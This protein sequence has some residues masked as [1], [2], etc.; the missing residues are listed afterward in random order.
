MG[1]ATRHIVGVSTL[2]VVDIEARRGGFG[3]FS[4]RSFRSSSFGKARSRAPSRARRS[5][6]GRSDSKAYSKNSAQRQFD[7][8]QGRRASTRTT[9]SQAQISRT[10]TNVRQ[11]VNSSRR[12]NRNISPTNRL[13]RARG[14]STP[15]NV[16]INRN[17]YGG[18]RFGWGMYSFGIWDLFFLN[19]MMQSNRGFYYHRMNQSEIA[20][21][22]KDKVFQQ[23]Q[24]NEL[25]AEIAQMKAQG[26]ARDPNYLPKG[27]DPDVPLAQNYVESQAGE[28]YG[29]KAA[30]EIA[31]R[32][33]EKD[34]KEATTLWK[35]LFI[36]GLA[37]WGGWFVFMRRV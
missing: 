4:R 11:Q 27:V 6:R 28:I 17:Y 26:I 32:D 18:G 16:V 7:Q 13:D 31:A 30:E 29:P 5:S 22:E 24:L 20:R 2:A 36:A 34:S 1:D 35:D 21:L 19:W 9:R 14:H 33:R 3:G 23:G 12:Q 8:R 37:I 10:N 15:R 25:K